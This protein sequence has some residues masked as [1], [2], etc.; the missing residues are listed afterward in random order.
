MYEWLPVV[1]EQL[2]IH[3]P[4][5]DGVVL[6]QCVLVRA[7]VWHVPALFDTCPLFA[8]MLPL[9]DELFPVVGIIWPVAVILVIPLIALLFNETSSIH[10]NTCSC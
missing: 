2:I 9:V 10:I 1:V 4:V 7:R 6:F 5:D 8:C 3:T